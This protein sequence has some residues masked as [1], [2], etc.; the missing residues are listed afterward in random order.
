M[1]ELTDSI[2]KI[3]SRDSQHG[4]AIL[5]YCDISLEFTN[6][7]LHD[8]LQIM[9]HKIPILKQYIIEK[10]ST[11]FLEDDIEFKL[12]NHYQIIY[13][14]F[15]HF[16]AYIDTILNSDFK[17]KSK[18]LFHYLV[19]KESKKYRVYFKIDHSYADGYKII[20]MLMSP[21][22]STHTPTQF[23]RNM[24]SIWDTLYYII[25][26]TI[27][28]LFHLCKRL[29]ESLSSTPTSINFQK[30]DYIR[31]RSFKLSDIKHV[32]QKY[33]ITVND[34]LYSLLVKTD[35]LYHTHNRDIVTLSPINISGSK[36]LNNM[37]PIVNKISNTIDNKNLFHTV[38]ET[39][40]SYKYS[41]YIPILSFVLHYIVPLLP[42]HIQSNMY[43]SLVH[44]CDYI[45]SNVIGPTH[46]SFEDIHFLT[47]AK[48]KEIVFNIISSNDHIN[49]I[50]SFKEGVI[51]DKRRFEECIYMAYENLMKTEV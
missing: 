47:L 50:C 28:L 8:H 51:Q 5:T 17:T 30:T 7:T 14:T 43:D 45:Y 27:V 16:D 42:L 3:F 26:G 35:S 31:C 21:L 41:L 1:I 18:W 12:E 10:N 20:E 44:R 38:H 36:H 33:H 25:I 4:Y 23:K 34:F 9:I 24:I 19:D 13:D 49:I 2:S 37:A 15:D 29:L 46:E 22:K 40:N 32:T 6:Q 39:F 11:I 48:D